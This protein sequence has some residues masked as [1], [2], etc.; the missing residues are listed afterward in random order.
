MKE[1]Y[2][3]RTTPYINAKSKLDCFLKRICR[4]Y[5]TKKKPFRNLMDMQVLFVQ[6]SEGLDPE[7]KEAMIKHPTYIFIKTLFKSETI[8]SLPKLIR[9]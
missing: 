2:F 5:V 9:G 3:S 4:I 8:D 1:E 6:W 7:V